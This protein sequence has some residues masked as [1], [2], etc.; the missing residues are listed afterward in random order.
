[1]RLF[2][3][4][5]R[6][7]IDPESV[8]EAASRLLAGS[9]AGRYHLGGPERLSRHAL[10]LRVASALGL[11]ADLIEAVRQP[12]VPMPAPRPPDVSL[13]SSRARRELGFE[14]RPLEQG[15]R[16]GRD[17]PDIIVSG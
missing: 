11:P 3:D 1:V 12:D 16:E 4:Q 14:P 7:T 10:G 5:Y 17:G 6:T 13:D 9:G 15:I 8:A 2:T